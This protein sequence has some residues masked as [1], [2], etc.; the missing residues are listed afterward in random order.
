MLDDEREAA[1]AST[2]SS[3]FSRSM[4]G[5]AQGLKSTDSRTISST[6]RD[7]SVANVVAMENFKK[8]LAGGEFTTPSL[9]EDMSSARLAQA[10][11]SATLSEDA[12]SGGSWC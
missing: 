7:C 12:E 8:A 6:L 9:K 4:L 11:V 10:D 2:S 1:T 5:P 3:E